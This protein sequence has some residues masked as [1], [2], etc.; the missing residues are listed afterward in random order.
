MFQNSAAKKALHKNIVLEK[1]AG[2]HDTKFVVPP[3]NKKG[4]N[5]I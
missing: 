3:L 4:Q 2:T 5:F 1:T